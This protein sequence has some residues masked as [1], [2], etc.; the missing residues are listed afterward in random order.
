[1]KIGVVIPAYK[2]A[3]QIG[4]V[5]Q[6][7]P[8]IIKHII[9]VDDKCPHFSGKQAEKTKDKRIEI[10]YHERN[11]GV[12]A[13]MI[14]GYEKAME[15]GCDIVIKM[16]PDFFDG[17]IGVLT[18]IMKEARHY[19]VRVKMQVSDDMSHLDPVEY[20][21]FSGAAFLPAVS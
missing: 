14:A 20:E 11:K 19:G 13:A 8:S 12:G 10:L 1:M 21:R 6:S 4:A 16:L 3:K 17:D 5:I 15:L 2:V 18:D 9:V 7:L